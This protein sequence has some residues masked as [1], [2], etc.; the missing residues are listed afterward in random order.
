MIT[1]GKPDE[2]QSISRY[3][4]ERVSVLIPAEDIERRLTELAADIS[5]DYAGKK[6]TLL[7]ALK[8]AVIFMVDLAR[9]LNHDVEFDFVNISSYGDETRPGAIQ[10]NS[11]PDMDI[12]GKHIL[13]VEDIVDTGH[14]LDYLR[15]NIMDN[16]PASFKICVLLDK[17][18]RRETENAVFE[19]LG[20]AIP[21][22]FVVG[23][24][25]DYAQRYRNLPY[26]GVLRFE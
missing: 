1:V 18:D 16:Q 17:P 24:G 14:T 19:Y 9:K 3:A 21:D 10:M 22:A 7:C 2:T 4:G 25:L 8:G 13:L 20:F 6:I 26:I 11:G 12:K 15:W 5:R 23:Y